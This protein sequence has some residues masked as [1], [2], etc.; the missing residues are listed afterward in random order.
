MKKLLV[1]L[2]LT[3]FVVS[4]ALAQKSVI[5]GRKATTQVMIDSV[6]VSIE[7]ADTSAAFYVGD[8]EY[9][10]VYAHAIA[11]SGSAHVRVTVQYSMDLPVAINWCQSSTQT[12]IVVW[13]DFT[14]VDPATLGSPHVLLTNPTTD[15][16][17]GWMRII[18]L[19]LGTNGSDTVFFLSAF[20]QP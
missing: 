11:A 15:N 18:A 9:I 13:A 2:L 12:D 19:G 20:K 8:A 5:I 6:A 4:S 10:T 7:T 1:F 3:F 14:Y 17:F 16:G